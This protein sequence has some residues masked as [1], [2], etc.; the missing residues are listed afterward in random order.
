[1]SSEVVAKFVRYT[2]KNPFFVRAIKNFIEKNH[3]KFSTAEEHKLE[4]TELHQEYEQMID[5]SIA[6]FIDKTP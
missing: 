6:L 2:Q 4:Y 1:M 5:T 3:S